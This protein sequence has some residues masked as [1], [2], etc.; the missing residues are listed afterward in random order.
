MNVYGAVIVIWGEKMLF[1]PEHIKLIASGCK[2]AT[3]RLWKK[4]HAKPNGV[5]PV[6]IR[7]FQPRKDCSAFIRATTVYQQRLGDMTEK[8]ADKEGG[9]T[10][11]EFKRVFEDITKTKW[12][13]DLVVWVIEFRIEGG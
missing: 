5:Y 3:R 9:Y 10:L 13:D 1:R 2:T 11:K 8:D 6:Q 12:E 4:T 7:M